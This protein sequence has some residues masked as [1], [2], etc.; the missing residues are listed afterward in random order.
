MRWKVPAIGVHHLEGHL[1]APLLEDDPPPFPHRGAAG[2]GR[3]HDADRGRRR[4]GRYQLLGETLDDAA[5]EAFDKTAKLLGLPYP[6]GPALAKLAAHGQAGRVRFSA[7]RCSTGRA[8]F[9]FLGPEDRGAAG[10]ARAATGALTRRTRADIAARLQEAIVETLVAQVA[11]RARADRLD[12]LVVA[13]GVGANRLLRERL[14]AAA[15]RQ[16]A[17]SLFPAHRVLHRQC[18]DDR[19][20]RHG[21]PQGRAA[22]GPGRRAARGHLAAGGAGK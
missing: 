20:R 19:G 11:A 6:G 18:R 16:G 12:A 10:L 3:A 13:G 14:A 4:I 21:A 22:R 2:L 5:G 9:Q 1:L 7:A 17:A 15:A 8:R